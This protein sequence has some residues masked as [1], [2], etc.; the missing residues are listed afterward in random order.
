MHLTDADTQQPIGMSNTLSRT[1]GK[2]KGMYNATLQMP[3]NPLNNNDH[4]EGA[5]MPDQAGSSWTRNGP[6]DG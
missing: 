4:G 1:T 2:T 5:L 3:G 6:H